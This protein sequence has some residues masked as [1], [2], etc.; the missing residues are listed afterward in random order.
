MDDF[1]RRL[2]GEETDESIAS[3]LEI[4]FDG[5]LY[6]Y[7]QHHYDLFRNAMREALAD[8]ARP[9]FVANARFQPSWSIAFSPT[10]DDEQ[11]MRRHGIGYVEGYYLYDCTRFSQLCDAIAFAS[12]HPNL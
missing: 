1:Y 5:E 10:E 2:R 11:T 9:G 12:S 7:R 6:V 8:R 3:R 4:S